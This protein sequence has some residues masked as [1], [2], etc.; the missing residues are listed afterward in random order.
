MLRSR[1]FIELPYA[2]GWEGGSRCDRSRQALRQDCCQQRHDPRQVVE[3]LSILIQAD[4]PFKITSSLEGGWLVPASWRVEALVAGASRDDVAELMRLDDPDR[5]GT[6][7]SSWDQMTQSRVRRRVRRARHRSGA[8]RD[9]WIRSRQHGAPSAPVRELENKPAPPSHRRGGWHSQT[10]SA[11]T[12]I[13]NLRVQPGASRQRCIN[14]WRVQSACTPP[15]F[16]AR[17]WRPAT[18]VAV[19]RRHLLCRCRPE[20]RQH[21][22]RCCRAKPHSRPMQPTRPALRSLIPRSR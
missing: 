8:G 18:D 15:W 16:D 1:Y 4:L 6:A 14:G 12:T 13:A 21:R 5:F 2:P 22:R 19:A 20:P 9:Q 11:R 10:A 3:Q 17:G 7:I